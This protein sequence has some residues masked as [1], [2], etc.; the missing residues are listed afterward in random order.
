MR[1]W[2]PQFWTRAGEQSWWQLGSQM[3]LR[4]GCLCP[5]SSLLLEHLGPIW[6]ALHETCLAQAEL[7]CVRFRPLGA[8]IIYIAG[9]CLRG[10]EAN[11]P[12]DLGGV[13]HHWSMMNNCYDIRALWIDQVI[14]KHRGRQIGDQIPSICGGKGLAKA[15]KTVRKTPKTAQDLAK[16]VRDN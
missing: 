8:T 15:S 13:E 11:V 1:S 4:V 9:K 10:H 16:T 6:L 3:G 5:H 7:P 14:S 12:L 2:G